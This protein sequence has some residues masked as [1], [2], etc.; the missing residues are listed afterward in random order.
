MTRWW[1]RAENLAGIS[2]IPWLG[3]HGLRRRFAS[4]LKDI[5]LRSLCDLGGWKD[6]D[7][8]VRSVWGSASFRLNCEGG[9][10][11]YVATEPGFGSGGQV[12]SRITAIAGLPCI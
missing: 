6:P 8:V 2:R 12:L 5:P 7:T 10:M 9:D 3:W 11:D 4:D 1:K